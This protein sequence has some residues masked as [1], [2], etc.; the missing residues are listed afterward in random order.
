MRL[1]V[2]ALGS[3]AI[4]MD[5]FV[6]AGILGDIGDD[7]DV[8]T[9][10]AG[11]LVTVFALGYAILAPVLAAATGR[12]PRRRVLL[13][14]MALFT[15][16][17]V[18]TALAPNYGVA[19][20]SRLL[21]AA[22]AAM[23]LPNAAAGAAALVAPERRA[24]ALA[25]LSGGNSASLVLGAP[26]GTWLGGA[27]GWHSTMWVIVGLGAVAML[28]MAI[29]LGPIPAGP[30]PGLRD[31]LRPLTDG[32]VLLIQSVT[33]VAFLAA[34][35]AYPYLGDVLA[36]AGAHHGG[37]L[38]WAL[39]VFGFGAVLG[40]TLAGHTV[41]RFGAD[42]TAVLA[43]TG[44]TTALALTIAARHAYPAALA[45][46]VLWGMTGWQIVVS[47]QHRL[48]SLDP[49]NAPV[50]ISLNASAQYLGVSLGGALGG[51]SVGPLGG[52][53]LT[54]LAAGIGLVACILVVLSVRMAADPRRVT[55]T[56]KAPAPV[57]AVEH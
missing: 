38:A 55:A 50:V 39:L 9:G 32:R 53:G 40:T 8:S 5:G 11:Q 45:V 30:V 46:L 33:F 22:G 14:A 54:A 34:F 31:R 10:A 29:S 28:G 27:Q 6:F 36:P 19:L 52:G 49:T 12:W 23:F 47:Q 7:L 4:G 41:D 56:P 48:I 26:F 20:G 13:T 24:R 57:D 51:A 15:A 2:L 35:T 17:N 16:G 42:R 18:V 3:F 25:V 1:L 44:I 43:V 21:A 37:P